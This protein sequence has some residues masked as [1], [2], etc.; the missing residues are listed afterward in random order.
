MKH[1]FTFFIGLF[2]AFSLT[3]QQSNILKFESSDT[4]N[5][6]FD[7]ALDEYVIKGS[8]KNISATTQKIK[9]KRK[10]TQF[11]SGCESTICDLLC[12]SS[13]INES[14]KELVLLPNQSVPIESHFYK[15]CAQ[16]GGTSFRMTFHPSNDLT[17]VLYT[18]VFNCGTTTNVSDLEKENIKITP[19]PVSQYFKI[20]DAN[21]SVGAINIYNMTG[22]LIKN[23][24]QSDSDEYFIGDLPSGLYLV[25]LSD[26]NNKTIKTLRIN[27]NNP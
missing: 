15:E 12:Y 19:N 10:Y 6:K 8:I 17:N 13:N 9:W 20:K 26:K 25:R 18:V 21:N 23:L 24:D 7:P 11:A 16:N 22:R 1:L 27:K 2:V 3:A 5:A 14:P 4:M